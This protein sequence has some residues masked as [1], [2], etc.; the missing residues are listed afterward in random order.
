MFLDSINVQIK[1]GQYIGIAGESGS[2]KTTFVDLVPRFYDV[3]NGSISIDGIDIRN[4]KIDDLRSM[5]GIVSQD[6]IL[7]ND[8]ISNN[9]SYIII[10][11]I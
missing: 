6:T 2:G 5:M 9:I 3:S 4:L 8:T 10:T 11:K 1:K 7:F